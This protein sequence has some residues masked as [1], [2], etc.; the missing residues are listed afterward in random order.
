MINREILGDYLCSFTEEELLCRTSPEYAET[1][2]VISGGGT[3]NS[4]FQTDSFYAD[5]AFLQRHL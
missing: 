5:A 3:G 4:D 1:L 2:P